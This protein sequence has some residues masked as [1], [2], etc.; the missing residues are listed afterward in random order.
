MPCY[1]LY[2]D[3]KWYRGLIIKIEKDPIFRDLEIFVKY[4]DF[5]NISVTNVDE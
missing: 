4:I 1:A 3:K 2:T 5:G